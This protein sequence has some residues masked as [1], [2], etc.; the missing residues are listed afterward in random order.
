MS[1]LR[2]KACLRFQLSGIPI[3][4]LGQCTLNTLMK[5]TN[6]FLDHCQ[7]DDVLADTEIWNVVL[8]N[9]SIKKF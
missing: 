2:L 1:N 3:L 5:I 7:W 6:A 8:G 9:E 4:S